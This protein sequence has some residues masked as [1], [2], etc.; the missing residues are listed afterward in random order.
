MTAP[1]LAVTTPPP[2]RAFWP[3]RPYSLIATTAS[4]DPGTVICSAGPASPKPGFAREV[5][6][7]GRVLD[8]DAGDHLAEGRSGGRGDELDAAGGETPQHALLDDGG[9]R[10]RR[11][12]APGR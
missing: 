1:A 9:H 6:Q 4:A 12:C 11:R 10:A 3:S 8:V 5:R 2:G 7:P